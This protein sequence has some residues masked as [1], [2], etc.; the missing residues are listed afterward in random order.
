M[1]GDGVECEPFRIIYIG[2][3]LIYENNCYLQVYLYV[4]DYQTV[5]TQMQIYLIDNL[6]LRLMKI[7]FLQN[8]LTTVVLQYN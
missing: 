7:I 5:D 2:S 6:F 4:C 8:S 1:S 3:L